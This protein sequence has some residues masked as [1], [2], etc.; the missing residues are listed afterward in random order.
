MKPDQYGLRMSLVRLSRRRPP[1]TV[2]LVGCGVIGRVH[3]EVLRADP[4]VSIAFVAD[5]RLAA[6]S[7]EHGGESGLPRYDDL[8]AALRAVEA[9]DVPSP[10]LFVLAT[11]T[12]VHLEH[13]SE[14]L[15]R[16]GADVFCEKPL[17]SSVA[18]LDRFER[19]HPDAMSRLAVVNHFAFSPEVSW[20]AGVAAGRGWGPPAHVLA[21]FND[22]YVRKT[23]AERASYVSSWI[24]SGP[25]QISVLRRFTD[26]IAVVT[27][28]AQPTGRGRSPR[29]PTP[30]V[31]ARSRRTGTPGRAASR[32]RCGGTPASSCSST[33]RR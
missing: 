8:D 29:S 26:D 32:R 15:S 33:T 16:T 17:T 27:T 22:P 3:L 19:D 2:G 23:E 14:V 30:A 5:R 28:R 4:R 12:P 11:P 9:G 21:S 1:L 20:G 13:A 31:P 6:S 24:D 7:S 10:D 25:N 18:D